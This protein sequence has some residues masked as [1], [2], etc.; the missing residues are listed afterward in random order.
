MGS[1][2]EAR[3]AVALAVEA[4]AVHWVEV[5]SRTRKKGS[6]CPLAGA[7]CV[8]VKV[9]RREGFC[10]VSEQKPQTKGFLQ[11]QRV[12]KNGPKSY[13]EYIL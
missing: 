3:Q 7:L 1:V 6:C 12:A 4:S 10:E 8:K 9:S 2:R 13:T 11:A 5:S